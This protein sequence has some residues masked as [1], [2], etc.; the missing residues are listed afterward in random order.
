LTKQTAREMTETIVQRGWSHQTG[1]SCCQ[2]AFFIGFFVLSIL[3]ALHLMKLFPGSET[4]TTAGLLII[5]F[6]SFVPFVIMVIGRV[7][8]YSLISAAKAECQKNLEHYLGPAVTAIL[9]AAQGGTVG[10]MTR[11]AFLQNLQTSQQQA[12]ARIIQG[13]GDQPET[14][15]GWPL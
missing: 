12:V 10:G 13:W 1:T 3:A 9:A 14:N 7:Y 2:N 15:P 11:A 4:P 8:R 5:V 6:G